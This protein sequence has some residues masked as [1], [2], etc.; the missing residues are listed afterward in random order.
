MITDFHSFG[1]EWKFFFVATVFSL[2]FLIL[3]F[4]ENL[5]EKRKVL[6]WK[7]KDKICGFLC[8]FNLVIWFLELKE[9]EQFY[10][11]K[12]RSRHL[13]YVNPYFETFQKDFCM[14][15]YQFWIKISLHH[16]S[17]DIKI[18]SIKAQSITK[19]KN[20]QK[21][22][23]LTKLASKIFIDQIFDHTLYKFQI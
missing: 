16:I 12:G 10:V 2:F 6:N 22:I 19:K 14:K 9:N 21:N 3:R 20:P 18:F 15:C 13:A 23:Y 5:I 7:S 17:I 11:V 1:A 4:K 8:G